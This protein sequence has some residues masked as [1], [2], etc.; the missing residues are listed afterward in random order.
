MIIYTRPAI[1]ITL[2]V[3][4]IMYSF[5]A[6]VFRYY[7]NTLFQSKYKKGIQFVATFAGYALLCGLNQM[8]LALLNLVMWFL[9]NLALL[10]LLYSVKIKTA[11]LHALM[12]PLSLMASEF[13]TMIIFSALFK[14]GFEDA[15]QNS[16]LYAIENFV[17]KLIFFSFMIIL[18]RIFSK[19]ENIRNRNYLSILIIPLS[20]AVI[21]IVFRY[22]LLEV[23]ITS[24][25]FYLWLAAVVL[26]MVSSVF[27]FVNYHTTLKKSQELSDL[28]L[29]KQKSDTDRAYIKLL[30][31]KREDMHAM[32]SD[33]CMQ[34]RE[35]QAMSRDE[36][37]KAY[38]DALLNE[39]QESGQKE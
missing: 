15:F 28:K 39:M 17:S 10:Y 29:E 27:V 8:H 4:I 24:T 37:V 32:Q 19:D 30:E 14:T 36:S 6:L 20:N 16:M 21:M 31:R 12:F 9:V 22:I 33:F 5:T 3:D 1:M 35:I 38:A 25:V 34:L 18:I 11:L 26:L 2:I 23:E 7:A 13:I